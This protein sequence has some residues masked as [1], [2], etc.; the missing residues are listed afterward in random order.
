MGSL[1]EHL[2]VTIYNELH[3]FIQS[4]HMHNKTFMQKENQLLFNKPQTLKVY[5]SQVWLIKL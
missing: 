3:I 5:N 1:K 2:Q 4:V